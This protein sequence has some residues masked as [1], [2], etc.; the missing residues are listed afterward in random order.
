MSW[1]G[2]RYKNMITSKYER[3]ALAPAVINKSAERDYVTSG[4]LASNI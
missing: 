4:E 2:D 1:N 3:E